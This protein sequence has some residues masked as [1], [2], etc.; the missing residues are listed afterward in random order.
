[1]N[2]NALFF[3]WQQQSAGTDPFQSHELN[4]TEEV[5]NPDALYS[6]LDM[7]SDDLQNGTANDV[8]SADRG[9]CREKVV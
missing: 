6:S 5:P 8:H 7:L 4:L 2:V 9:W 1:M 3:S